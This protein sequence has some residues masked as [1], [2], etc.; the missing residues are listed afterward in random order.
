MLL[1]IHAR[2]H[3]SY[4]LELSC[5]VAGNHLDDM[6]LCPCHMS[7]ALIELQRYRSALS[8]AC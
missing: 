7:E 1:M 2:K 8:E 3:D 4:Q 5:P 6:G